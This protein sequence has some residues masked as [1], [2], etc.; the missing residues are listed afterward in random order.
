MQDSN[1]RI[2]DANVLFDK[3]DGRQAIDPKL[4][5][6]NLGTDRS[7]ANV[8]RPRRN[9]CCAAENEDTPELADRA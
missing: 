8:I 7:S 4:S 1:Q 6:M 5:R 2:Q 3:P 9:R